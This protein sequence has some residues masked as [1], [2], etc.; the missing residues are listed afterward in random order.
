[1]RGEDEESVGATDSEAAIALLDRLL[2]AHAGAVVGPGRASDLTIADRDR[3]LA[4]AQLAE[5][6]VR[7]DST[8]RCASCAKP[9]DIDFDLAA[10]IETMRREAPAGT[11]VRESGGVYRL[12]GGCRFR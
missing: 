2:V 1:M 3:L 11:A 6:G 8:V 12:A 4:D 7:I 5:L 10:L 9:F